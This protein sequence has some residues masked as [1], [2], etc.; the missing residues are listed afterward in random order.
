[1]K[2]RLSEH[3][4]FLK[5]VSLLLVDKNVV[6]HPC[7][8]A[9]LTYH[10]DNKVNRYISLFSDWIDDISL[11]YVFPT[12]AFQE[13]YERFKECV[14]NKTAP[15]YDGPAISFD[16]NKVSETTY[17]RD[18]ITNIARRLKETYYYHPV[19]KNILDSAYSAKQRWGVAPLH[20]NPAYEANP[21]RDKA[22]TDNNRVGHWDYGKDIECF[23]MGT[24]HNNYYAVYFLSCFNREMLCLTA[25]CDSVYNANKLAEQLT[26]V[27]GKTRLKFISSKPF[28]E[29]MKTRKEK[30]EAE[31]PKNRLIKILNK[32]VVPAE[33][34]GKRLEWKQL[35]KT[36]ELM[37]FDDNVIKQLDGFVME[38]K[39][40]REIKDI[41]PTKVLGHY[42]TIKRTANHG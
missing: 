12:P 18:F 31:R 8:V 40:K 25:A 11:H 37:S 23:F 2:R 21:E 29:I 30:L 41:P 42:D 24:N 10:L 17:R 19:T 36:L 5:K 38:I 33:Q 3:D 14:N 20:G 15:N 1:M 4:K 39:R 32:M 34:E 7:N 27:Y 16:D 26:S 13:R 35:I 28:Q 9:L 22:E 6:E